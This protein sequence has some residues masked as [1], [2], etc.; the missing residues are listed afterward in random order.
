MLGNI[1]HVKRIKHIIEED[2]CC[3]LSRQ[4]LSLV[5]IKRIQIWFIGYRV[6][7]CKFCANIFWVHYIVLLGMKTSS[8]YK[9][10]VRIILSWIP[11]IPDVGYNSSNIGIKKKEIRNGR[12]RITLLF[13]KGFIMWK[14]RTVQEVLSVL[15]KWFCLEACNYK[16][17]G[18][19]VQVDTAVGFYS[20]KH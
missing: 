17:Q 20:Y 11:F 1:F 7:L 6:W 14:S 18:A 15:I 19:A 12:R 8:G 3:I 9:P 10:Y 16:N 13:D 4:G 2:S 5:Y